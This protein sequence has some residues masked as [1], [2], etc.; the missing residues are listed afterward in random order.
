MIQ[1]IITRAK[2]LPKKLPTR[3]LP[4]IKEIVFK[5]ITRRINCLKLIKTTEKY[6]GKRM[7]L[8]LRILKLQSDTPNQLNQAPMAFNHLTFC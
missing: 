6:S 5:Y 4:K 1:I 3:R 7:D 2:E 8:N